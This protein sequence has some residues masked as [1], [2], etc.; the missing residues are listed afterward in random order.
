MSY[1]TALVAYQQKRI[2]EGNT[3]LGRGDG[4]HAARLAAGSFHIGLADNFYISG[5]ATPRSAL[6]LFGEVLR[7]PQP[8]DW[9]FD[10]MESLAVL[11]TPHP[12][13]FEHWF[14]A[15]VERQRT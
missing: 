7:D 2:P 6:D 10:P 12:L 1:L 3:R 11:M 5:V 14:E 13:P 9:A 8:A 15:A 4:L